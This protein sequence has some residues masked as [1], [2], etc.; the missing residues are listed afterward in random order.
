MAVL[1]S[2]GR[3]EPNPTQ[4]RSDDPDMRSLL[5]EQLA[6]VLPKGSVF[7]DVLVMMVG[8]MGYNTDP[9]AGR[10]LGE[11]LLSPP[12]DIHLLQAVKDC[13]KA[14]SSALDSKAEAALATTVYYASLAGALVRHDRKITRHSYETLDESFT[15]LMEKDWMAPELMELFARAQ[16]ICQSRRG[17][18]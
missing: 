3:E 9:L 18:R 1:F 13:S 15:L 14:M 16:A 8:G 6:C 5:R 17:E 10:S 12:S 4:Q 11:I 2:L 7:C